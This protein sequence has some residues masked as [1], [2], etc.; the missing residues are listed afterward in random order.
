MNQKLKNVTKKT[1]SIYEELNLETHISLELLKAL[2]IVTVDEKINQDSRRK[3]KQVQVLRK[4]K[5]ITLKKQTLAQVLYRHPIH[6]REFASLLT[7]VLRGLRLEASGYKVAVTEF[8]G[9]EH[10]FLV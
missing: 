8:V 5:S 4:I 7:N 2:H 9:F 3:L 10:S 1:K 6:T